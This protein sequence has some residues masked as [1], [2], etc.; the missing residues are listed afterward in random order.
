MY[1][2]LIIT[3][4]WLLTDD[5]TIYQTYGIASTCRLRNLCIL[6]R[7]IVKPKAG[8]MKMKLQS[9]FFQVAASIILT[10]LSAG[11]DIEGEQPTDESTRYVVTTIAE[12]VDTTPPF[13]PA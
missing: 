13:V 10:L 5:F 11:C 1:Q 2:I 9:K 6:T 12:A 4:Y 3:V 8:T 7:S